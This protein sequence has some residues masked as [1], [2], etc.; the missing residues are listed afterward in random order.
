V[1]NT[2]GRRYPFPSIGLDRELLGGV[3]VTVV[4]AIRVGHSHSSRTASHER[5]AYK[6]LEHLETAPT[7]IAY[8]PLSHGFCPR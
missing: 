5:R 4:H 3:V 7:E 6:L 2:D 8:S 1:D